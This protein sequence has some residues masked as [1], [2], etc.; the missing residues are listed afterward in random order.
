[1]KDGYLDKLKRMGPCEK[2]SDVP[3]VDRGGRWC[4]RRTGW[5]IISTVH[6]LFSM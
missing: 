5:W 2:V 1:M 3:Y 4:S 6:V